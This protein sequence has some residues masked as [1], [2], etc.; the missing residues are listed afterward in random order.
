MLS[1]P[2]RTH[3]AKFDATS[4]A[5]LDYATELLTTLQDILP[6]I[7]QTPKELMAMPRR[8]RDEIMKSRR[9]IVRALCERVY[10]YSDWSIRIEGVLDGGE[11]RRFGLL[12]SS[13]S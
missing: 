11:G 12:S 5:G 13:N 8:E 4:Q 6:D 7:D 9:G 3:V 2:T 10:V 1:R